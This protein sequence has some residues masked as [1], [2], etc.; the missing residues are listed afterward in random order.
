MTIQSTWVNHSNLFS[1]IN[2]RKQPIFNIQNEIF[3]FNNYILS[4]SFHTFQKKKSTRACFA[5]SDDFQVIYILKFDSNI[6]STSTNLITYK[7]GYLFNF[8]KEFSILDHCGMSSLC[9]DRAVVSSEN[10]G[11]PYL[12][13]KYV[14]NAR[15]W[16]SMVFT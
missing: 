3:F 15:V 9:G 2:F 8:Q 16:I 11:A 1:K 5:N 12:Q 14:K 10:P 4:C 7:T 13:L 6:L